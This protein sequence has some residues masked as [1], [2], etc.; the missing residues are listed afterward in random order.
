MG[1]FWA[2]ARQPRRRFGS[3]RCAW[4]TAAGRTRS[5]HGS[6]HRHVPVS[7]AAQPGV[8][9]AGGRRAGG[10]PAVQREAREELAAMARVVGPLRA[11]EFGC[12]IRVWSVSARQLSTGRSSGVF[13][14]HLHSR[15]TSRATSCSCPSCWAPA[16]WSSSRTFTASRALSSAIR[17]GRQ[18]LRASTSVPAASIKK[19]APAA[20]AERDRQP[21]FEQAP[22]AV[23]LFLAVEQ[24]RRR[25]WDGHDGRRDMPRGIVAANLGGSC[26]RSWSCGSP[27]PRPWQTTP[28]PST[29]SAAEP[30]DGP[31]TAEGRTGSG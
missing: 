19:G 2:L 30:C 25:I 6:L 1:A 7:D 14:S 21:S 27:S 12:A 23:W 22:H 11:G 13:A 31:C 20:P 8:A 15:R 4:W 16:R 17:G 10:A 28:S 3:G 29:G 9:E 24:V 26:R 18:A 5:S